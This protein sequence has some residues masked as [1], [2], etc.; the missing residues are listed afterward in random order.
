MT[1]CVFLYFTLDGW[2]IYGTAAL[3]GVSQA[4]LLISSLRI[5]ANLINCNTESSA[6]VY[7]AMSF[8]DKFSN[9]VTCQIVEILNPSCQ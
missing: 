4:I 6:F 5:T 8:L 7:G 2:K 3:L 1:N 9:G